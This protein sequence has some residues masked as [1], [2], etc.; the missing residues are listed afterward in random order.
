VV[1]GGGGGFGEAFQEGAFVGVE[2][3]VVRA[4]RVDRDAA[5]CAAEEERDRDGAARAAAREEIAVVRGI[6]R[7]RAAV[8]A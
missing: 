7:K 8:G 1:E 4:L 5:E 2:R 6:D 3:G